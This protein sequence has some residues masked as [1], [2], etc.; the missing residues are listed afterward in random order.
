LF[1]A[2]AFE[3][4]VYI[5]DPQSDTVG[6]SVEV[7]STPVDLVI[8]DNNDKLLVANSGLQRTFGD[9]ITIVDISAAK[10]DPADA[11]NTILLSCINPPLSTNFVEC[12]PTNVVT[13]NTIRLCCEFRRQQ[14]K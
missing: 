3:D 4:R 8:N 6:S 14:R 2:S 12:R 11:S 9:S 1:A 5:I 10:I 7:G 13:N